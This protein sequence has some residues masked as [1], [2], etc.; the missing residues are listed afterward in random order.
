[1]SSS[2]QGLDPA[3]AAVAAIDEL[4]RLLPDH[5]PFEAMALGSQLR[6]IL[7]EAHAA[8]P[9][10]RLDDADFVRFL[11][12]R[13]SLP[14]SAADLAKL[15]GSD[16]FLV[17]ACARGDAAALLRLDGSF[18]SSLPRS[19]RRI[20][21]SPSFTDEVVQLVRRRLLLGDGGRR[22]R[23]FDYGGRGSLSGWLRVLA[24][25]TALNLRESARPTEGLDAAMESDLIAGALGPEQAL[26]KGQIRAHFTDAL[27]RALGSLSVEERNLLRLHLV[28]SL[29]ID[30]LA[31]MFQIH[32][33]TAA[34]R[35]ERVRL[36]LVD[37]MRVD[38]TDAA[39]IPKSQLD[40][41]LNLV[42][43]GLD[44]S[45]RCGST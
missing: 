41:A 26:I 38:L 7:E 15:H 21:P 8:W 37:R 32:R 34:R 1:M 13:L 16:L 9:T 30:R 6:A 14:C 28:E 17:C 23:I 5:T 4:V 42:L 45:L 10:I 11:S 3:I 43:S 2:T 22:P 29:S 40:S 39:G 20:D 35:I 27:C 31:V 44:L 33:S 25:R 36:L 12:E 18:L 24:T 19:L